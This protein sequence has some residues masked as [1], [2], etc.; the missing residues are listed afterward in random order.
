MRQ[1]WIHGAAALFEVE[2]G[3]RS[4]ATADS[5][6][7]GSGTGLSAGQQQ[8]PPPH[9]M[10]SY[11][12][13]HQDVILRVVA[14][15]QDRGYLVWV[16]TEQMKGATV[17]T[18]ALAVEGSEVVLI[19]VSRAY[20]E[21]S[22]CRMEAQY[23]L[24]KKKPLV[25]LMMTE[26]Y[27]A[28][29]W[30]G[31]LLGTSMWYGFYGETLTSGSVFDGRMDALCR[32]I[33]SRGRADAMVAASSPSAAGHAMSE[34]G[35]IDAMSD[36]EME[37][38][39]L[40]LMALQKRAL[41]AG[42]SE[43]SVEDAMESADQ[44]ASLIGLI[45]DI[46]SRR[47]PA[48]HIRSC[49]EGGGEACAEM[50]SDVLD[51]A[52]DV[53]E[54]LSVS[55]PRKYRKGLLETMEHVESVLEA[56]T[57]E[58]C[59]GVSR[60]G[61]DELEQL[62]SLLVSV[63]GLSSSSGVSSVSDAVTALLECLDRCGSVVVQSMAVLSGGSDASD[64]SSSS[65]VLSALESLRCLSDERLNAVSADE[66]A[67]YEAVLGHLSGLDA[68]A[69]DAVVS[70]C[71][72][73]H[74]L[75]CR[76]GVALCGRVDALEL[77]GAMV[78]RWLEYASSGGDDYA[79]AAAFGAFNNLCGWEGGWKMASESRQ[80]IEKAAVATAKS[81][82]GTVSKVFT[83]QSARKMFANSMRADVLS[84][85]DISLACGWCWVLFFIGYMHPGALPTANDSG[86]FS[87]ALELY[88][89]VEPSPLS[90]EW[91]LKTCDVV[92]VT[93]SQL[94]CL[95]ALLSVVKR[96]PS[97]M[98]SSWWSELFDHAI[99]LVNINASASLS[100]RDTLCQIPILQSLALIE[101]AAQDESQHDM[102][103]AS[104]VADALEYGILH[105]FTYIGSSTAAYASGAAVA[106]VGRNEGGKVLRCE[107]V[108]AVLER[109]HQCFQRDTAFFNTP[110]G[111]SV[112]SPR[113]S[114]KGLFETME[115]VESRLETVVDAGWCDGVC[116][117]GEE[118][119]CQLSSL[120]VSVRGL[121]SL[122]SG[123]SETS[124]A[125]TAL[126]ECLDR[127][128]SVVVQSM[129]V[130]SGGSDASDPSSSS[131]LSALESLRCL[132]D[133]RLDGVD[134]DEAAAYEAVLGHLSGMDACAGVEV[135]SSCMALHTLGCRNGVALCGRVD[136]ME[137]AGGGLCRWLEY[138][139]SGGD[140]YEAGGAVGAL[141]VL[142]GWEGGP[143]M[144][145]ESREPIE[146]AAQGALKTAFGIAGKVF[147]E[148]GAGKVYISGMKAGMLS[149]EDIS[150][151][152]GWGFILNLIGY[153]HPGALPTANESGVFSAAL[154]L[155]RRV[156]PSPLPGEWWLKTCAVVDVT[157][158]QLQ[159]LWATFSLMHWSTASCT[160]SQLL[161]APSLH[162]HR[163]Q[164][165]HWSVATREARCCVV[166][167]CTP[168]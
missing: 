71:M 5:D 9:V 135:V 141:Q 28:D 68:C 113:K 19:G 31:L 96:L 23:A 102:L 12:W 139:S 1:L 45:V 134:A 79:A 115:H 100:G 57:V 6:D 73:L 10:A 33:G 127:C 78:C 87:T 3:K 70:S 36:L 52:M 54:G 152:C 121:S 105:D 157:S 64:S 53:L 21:S 86:V 98:Q 42:A 13:D 58:W 62:C 153:M 168:C 89:R 149:H 103:I 35:V 84:H 16:D 156:E 30:L 77:A 159:C 117:C 136:V 20:K 161:A 14:S 122:S 106:L 59:D 92:D 145:S 125:V 29:G 112:S 4:K 131:V 17:D 25:P 154:E 41:S 81:V 80:P 118:E 48:D 104:G 137:L 67:A 151:A 128:G 15:L 126:L 66:A 114:R 148:Q 150:L 123:V 146:K 56:V 94:A 120:L 143:K 130:L 111:L 140:D 34:A 72:A 11:N 142:C 164:L 83:E 133:E 101:V 40:K 63:R 44:K 158:S 124:D 43:E 166:R 18:M 51:H 38:Q 27:E 82:F 69:G 32:E 46:E 26:G 75:G 37:L 167:L 50:I 60:C 147:T 110:Q 163:E 107:A 55:S 93:S 49:L 88:R 138:A 144:P 65:S 24:Q 99:Q 91:W 85:D 95:W 90:G 108:H 129:A 116:Q 119:M 160:T 132:S 74:T 76:N 47:G 97:A 2:D 109:L 22:N 61:P 7:D 39:E 155:Y 162:M 165:L 8:K